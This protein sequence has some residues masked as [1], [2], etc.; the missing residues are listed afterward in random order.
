MKFDDFNFDLQAFVSSNGKILLSS[1]LY[2]LE[3]TRFGEEH[4]VLG[5]YLNLQS[6]KEAARVYADIDGYEDIYIND[7]RVWL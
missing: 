4:H 3:C 7:T 5:Y 1:K 6:A 2:I